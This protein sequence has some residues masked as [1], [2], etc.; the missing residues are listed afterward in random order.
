[1][2][3]KIQLAKTTAHRRRGLDRQSP[4]SFEG[5]TRVSMAELLQPRQTLAL[6]RGT[7]IH[8]WFEQVAWSE[9]G[10]PDEQ[11]M[12]QIADEVQRS[13]ASSLD[14]VKDLA[15]F[16]EMLRHAA[17]ASVLSQAA[18]DT[19][20]KLGFGKSVCDALAGGKTR[21]VVENERTFAVRIV[22]QLLSGSIDRLVWIYA[23]DQLVAADI[24][25]FKTDLVAD[26]AAVNQK[27]EY[28][29]PQLES[30]RDAVCRMS[31]LT[32]DRVIARLVFVGRGLVIRVC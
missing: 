18:Y 20:S 28:Y 7:L 31:G 32:A 26:D 3:A 8:A 23:G 6:A 17:I 9:E 16:Q 22:S 4:S 21:L 24:I 1:L 27:R 11:R 2:P 15:A 5:G 25:D 19:P 30:Y 14:F 10:L 29:R 12:R 13:E